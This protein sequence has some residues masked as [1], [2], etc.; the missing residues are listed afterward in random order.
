MDADPLTLKAT[1]PKLKKW[2][3]PRQVQKYGD[4]P[5]FWQDLEKWANLRPVLRE[6][7]QDETASSGKRSKL[8]LYEAENKWSNYVLS[9]PIEALS[10]RE[11]RIML[12]RMQLEDVS[13]KLNN[14]VVLAQEAEK[15][16]NRSPSPDPV[17]NAQGKRTNT[18]EVR[19]RTKFMQQR[20]KLL[21]DILRMKPSL[22]GSSAGVRDGNAA[23][24]LQRKI[25][26]PVKDFPGRNFIGLIIGPRGDTQKRLEQDTGCKIAIRGKGSVKAGRQGKPED[27]VDELHVIVTG[28]NE[29]AV[30]R[31]SDQV[32]KLLRPLDDADNTH[33][34]EQLKQL[35]MYNGTF[36]DHETC[37]YCGGK[38]HKQWE[39]P[40][41]RNEQARNRP[42]PDSR[43]GSFFGQL[44]CKYCGE[45][46]HPSADCPTLRSRQG[47]PT[48]G[49]PSQAPPAPVS[50]GDDEFNDFWADINGASGPSSG[51]PGGPPI[52][53]P[54]LQHAMPPPPMPM[55]PPMP[56]PP[57]P[58]PPDFPAPPPPRS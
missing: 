11:Q 22:A 33:K 54:S 19:M 24:K 37:H 13:V 34:Q 20:K 30:D 2:Y 32:E 4:L 9:D 14:V 43:G 46:S 8:S 27:E 15:D 5:L 47:P 28:P 49:V 48:L 16:P 56:P 18:R 23:P 57:M 6:F 35:A 58:P 17:Y 38:G 10:V 51:P 29:E 36:R 3:G 45:R 1:F 52:P 55:P 39:C 44:Q 12:A 26:I 40:D 50:G 7:E 21:D 31:A 53:P 25:Y 41:K 42:G